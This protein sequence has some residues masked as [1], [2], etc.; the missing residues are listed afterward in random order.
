[1]PGSS[2]LHATHR[3][4]VM[5]RHAHRRGVVRRHARRRGVVRRH[6]HRRG[7][8]RRHAHKMPRYGQINKAGPAVRQIATA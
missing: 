8:V 5:R 7:M 6:A 4:G 3:R 2:L 1:L